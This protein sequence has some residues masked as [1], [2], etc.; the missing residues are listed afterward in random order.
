MRTF[1]SPK[2][3]D[4][5]E[6]SFQ[7]TESTEKLGA[8]YR[9][10]SDPFKAL[11]LSLSSV[12]RHSFRL[13][14]LEVL[15]K[16]TLWLHFS[17]RMRAVK[18]HAHWRALPQQTEARSQTNMFTAETV[19]TQMVTSRRSRRFF[20]PDTL[21]LKPVLFMQFCL[22]CFDL[23][24]FLNFITSTTDRGVQ[25]RRLPITQSI[26][27]VDPPSFLGEIDRKP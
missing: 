3:G 23:N 1:V 11:S 14:F 15:L 20:L 18:S 4:R 9:F 2:C 25:V 19:R 13:A 26:P 16:A 12:L 22:V 27:Q 8:K 7:S 24:F 5:A 21:F 17:H 10:Q 6:K